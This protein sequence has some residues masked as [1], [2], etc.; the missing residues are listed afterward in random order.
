MVGV[1][2]NVRYYVLGKRCGG[3]GRYKTPLILLFYIF[4]PAVLLARILSLSFGIRIFNLIKL[5]YADESPIKYKTH[6]LTS[7]V[8]A[9]RNGAIF[10]S[11]ALY[12]KVMLGF[13]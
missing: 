9:Q 2:H 1:A 8:Y 10:D 12:L 4:A 11:A 5:Y 13:A 6:D 3:Q 7:L